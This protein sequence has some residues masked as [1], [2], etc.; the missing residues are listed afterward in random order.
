MYWLRL[1]SAKMRLEWVLRNSKSPI[2]SAVMRYFLCVWR[3][4]V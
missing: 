4:R 3:V 1:S 2:I